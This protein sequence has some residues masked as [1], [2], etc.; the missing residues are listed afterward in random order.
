M[1]HD[2][3]CE[4]KYTENILLQF[5]HVAFVDSALSVSADKS[6]IF[7]LRGTS[8]MPFGWLQEGHR[9]FTDFSLDW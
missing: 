7:D 6:M 8:A 5:S 9:T 3:Q 4:L 1:C 2:V